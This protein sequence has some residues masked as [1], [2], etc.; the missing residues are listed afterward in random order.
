MTL[1]ENLYG[2]IE[3]IQAIDIHS[4]VRQLTPG[5]A[6]LRELLGYHYYTEL[7]YSCGLP[8]EKMADALPDDRMVPALLEVATQYSNTVQY[9]WIIELARKLFDFK[10]RHLTVDNWQP[11]AKVAAEK[12]SADDWPQQVLRRGNIEKVF[13]TN[14]FSEELDG[15]DRKTFVPCLRCDDLVFAIGQKKTLDLLGRRSGVEVTDVRSLKRAVGEIFN[16][17]ATHDAG[18]AAISLPPDFTFHAVTDAA[19]E[20]VLRAAL[21]GEIMTHDQQA[22]LGAYGFMLLAENCRQF[23]LPMQLMIGAVRDA[24]QHGVDKGTDVVSNRGS[25]G[26][27]AE[28]FNRFA[29]V[30]FS[31]SYLSP[32]MQHEL[33]TYTW[34]FQN[35]RASGHWWYAN[36][37]GYIES[38][39]RTR[40]E[41]LPQT[42]LLGYYSDAYYIEFTLPKFNMYR[43]C[44]ARVL[45]E[46]MEMKRLTEDESL[47]IARRLL[48][49]NALATFRI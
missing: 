4:H 39:L 15:F 21:A 43:W 16:Y 28:L 9:G 22:L 17:F 42:K 1:I 32:T 38:D 49:D 40:I 18:S 19:A 48:R 47:Q 35:V 45:A 34:I 44:L 41:A 20:P 14:H 7:A 2:E 13:L 11:L 26:Q 23:R 24:Y 25:L 29:D 27:Y 30:T 12:Q 5:G 46:Q 37:P 3:K 10:D 6:S 31:V 33:L 36:I 8:K